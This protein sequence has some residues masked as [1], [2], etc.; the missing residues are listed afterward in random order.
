MELTLELKTQLGV[1][2]QATFRDAAFGL[3][4]FSKGVL[5]FDKMDGV[6]RKEMLRYLRE[7]AKAMRDRHS[8]AWP[9]GT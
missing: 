7:T 9:G 8:G 3:E 1:G 4:K 5:S 2:S 6:L